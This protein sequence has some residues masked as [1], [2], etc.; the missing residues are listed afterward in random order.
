MKENTELLEI[1]KQ[2]NILCGRREAI[3]NEQEK[4]RK[5]NLISFLRNHCTFEIFVTRKCGDG[6]PFFSLCVY[7]ESN[8]KELDDFRK[9]FRYN[10]SLSDKVY[11]SS[12]SGE[13]KILCNSDIH[14]EK[15]LKIIF[16]WMVENGFNIKKCV[17]VSNL[18]SFIFA[19]REELAKL[20]S[21]AEEVERQ[22][23]AH[24]QNI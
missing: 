10:F 11:L 13:L 20:E 18:N 9:I 21:I 6:E 8:E 1:N 17:Y 2:I 7:C 16:D 3:E 12:Q 24:K 4:E 22:K 14:M 23:S 19:E 5:N 15:Q